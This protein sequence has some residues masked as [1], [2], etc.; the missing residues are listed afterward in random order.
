[1]FQVSRIKIRL[2]GSVGS[3]NGLSYAELQMPIL[4]T[5]SG[6]PRSE[7]S[8]RIGH[9]EIDDADAGVSRSVQNARGRRDRL[10]DAGDVDARALEHSALRAEVV[11]HVD[12]DDRRRCRYRSQ[13]RP[14]WPRS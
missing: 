10:L 6:A 5:E 11:L 4:F 2:G 8:G 13:Y 9:L 3:V 14:V 7:R 12:D 1:M